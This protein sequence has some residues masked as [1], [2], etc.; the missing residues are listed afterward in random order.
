ME[1][2]FKDDGALSDS[3]WENNYQTM[4]K[5]FL[6]F[7][8]SH[9]KIPFAFSFTGLQLEFLQSVHP[10]AME[11]FSEITSRKQGEVLGGGFYTPVFPLLFPVDRSGQIK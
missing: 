2:S 11:I 7:L 5:K 4:L 10:E 9:P 3:E 8:Y 1:L 6:T